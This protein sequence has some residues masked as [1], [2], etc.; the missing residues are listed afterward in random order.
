MNDTMTMKRFDK[1]S[2]LEAAERAENSLE[3]QPSDAGAGLRLEVVS[4]LASAL[5]RE[6]EAM[7]ETRPPD[8]T[9]RI[10]LLKEVR[11]FEINLILSALAHTS[12]HQTR[13]AQLLGVKITTL[14]AKIKRYGIEPERY[15]S[16]PA[17]AVAER[18]A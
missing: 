9:R 15:M 14:N 10:N 16:I 13:A 6:V 2:G 7:K 12:G 17:D 4:E 5:S 18:A 3:K 1:A 8:V 11:R